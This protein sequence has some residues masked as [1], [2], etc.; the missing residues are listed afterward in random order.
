MSLIW[1]HLTTLGQWLAA[2]GQLRTRPWQ[3]LREG[4]VG[5]ARARDVTRSDSRG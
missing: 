1:A 4:H 3:Q 5:P 2:G